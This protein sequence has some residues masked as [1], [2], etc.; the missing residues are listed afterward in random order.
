MRERGLKLCLCC[1]KATRLSS[2]P[3]RERGLKLRKPKVDGNNVTSLPV[4]ERGLKQ[5]LYGIGFPK[6]HV[7][8]RAGAWIET[9][10]ERQKPL[11]KSVAHVHRL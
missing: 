1:Q 7:A 10:L 4:R 9:P 11:L 5:W 8:P 3:V 2:L 6:S